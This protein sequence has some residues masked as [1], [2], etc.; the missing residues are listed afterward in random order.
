MKHFPPTV[1]QNLN[2]I[3]DVSHN[4]STSFPEIDNI[5]FFHNFHWTIFHFVSY[6]RFLNWIKNILL[7]STQ[8]QS[9]VKQNTI[10]TNNKKKTKTNPF[11]TTA[12]DFIIP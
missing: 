8:G 12:T 1:W 10:L 11:T 3:W 5:T 6:L 2:I 7:H 9:I 4:P